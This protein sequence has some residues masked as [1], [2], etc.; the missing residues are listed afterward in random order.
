MDNNKS[1]N[2]R[3][4]GPKSLAVLASIGIDSRERLQSIGAIACY[5][6]VQTKC[7]AFKPSLNLLYALP[8]ATRLLI[9]VFLVGA[10]EDRD[11]REVARSEK[12]R[13]ITELQAAVEF[14]AQT[15]TS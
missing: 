14:Q 5:L 4:L 15:D 11:W 6:R 10:I 9:A 7:P 2:L 3:G 13:L 12:L 8:P 1:Q